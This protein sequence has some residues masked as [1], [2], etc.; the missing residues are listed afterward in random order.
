M[1][2]HNINNAVFGLID[3]E[4]HSTNGFSPEKKRS[5]FKINTN[6]HAFKN[7]GDL[8]CV[9]TDPIVQGQINT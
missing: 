7:S 2:T 6:L 1:N 8:A 9:N 5:S 3:F 4:S